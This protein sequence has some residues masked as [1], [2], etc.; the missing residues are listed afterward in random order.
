MLSGLGLHESLPLLE[1]ALARTWL[2][3]AKWA[4]SSTDLPLSGSFF[5]LPLSESELPDLL[6]TLMGFC[7]SGDCVCRCTCIWEGEPLGEDEVREENVEHVWLAT[8]PLAVLKPDLSAAPLALSFLQ[9]E[10]PL[11]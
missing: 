6:S 5:P 7:V 4:L 3:L 11:E 10:L 2:V 8:F 9:S 1:L